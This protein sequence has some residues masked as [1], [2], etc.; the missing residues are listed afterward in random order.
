[1]SFSNDVKKEICS[2][3]KL[4]QPCKAILLYGALSASRTFTDK[5]IELLSESKEVA[6]YIGELITKIFNKKIFINQVSETKGKILFQIKIEDN[7]LCKEISESYDI[8]V[9]SEYVNLL[10]LD[11]NITWSFIKGVFLTS[12]SVND[13][14]ADYHLEFT[15]KT[16]KQANFVENMLSSL[17]LN[18]KISQRRNQFIVYCKDSTYIEDSLTGIGAVKSVLKLMDSKLIKDLRNRINRKN[19]CETANMQKVISA[20][21]LQVDAI[22]LIYLK[23]GSEFLSDDLKK[24]ADCRLNNPDLSLN[25]LVEILN[26]EFSKSGLDRRLKKLINIANEIKEIKRK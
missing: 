24:V 23:K 8:G 7:F 13:P 19:N 17:G 5:R 9:Y 10:A 4:T 6:Y 20:A 11:E 12:G 18:F 2:V 25:E 21:A 14:E 3:Y 16:K 26:N 22:N 1:M 15:L